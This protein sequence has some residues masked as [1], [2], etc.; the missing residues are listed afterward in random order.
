MDN[1]TVNTSYI[2]SVSFSANGKYL[3]VCSD[4]EFQIRNPEKKFELIY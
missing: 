3:A 2:N 1:L 4:E